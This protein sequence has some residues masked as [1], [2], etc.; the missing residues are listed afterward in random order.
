MYANAVKISQLH[1]EYNL[2]PTYVKLDTY[3]VF[4]DLMINSSINRI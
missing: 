3:N 1:P 4:M 2:H